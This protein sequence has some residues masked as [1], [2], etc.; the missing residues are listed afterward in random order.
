MTDDTRRPD[1]DDPDDDDDVHVLEEP[2]GTSYDD[3]LRELE[4]RGG[5]AESEGE[6]GVQ[7]I[8][9]APKPPLEVDQLAAER[10]ELHDRWLRTRADFDNYRKRAERDKRDS[11]DQA[12]IATVRTFLPVVDNLDRALDSARQHDAAGALLEGIEM[13]RFQLD[14]I[15]LSLG[16]ESVDPLGE[17]FDPE[18][19]EAIAREARDDVAPHQIVDVIQKGYKLRGRLVR[20]AMV[21]VAVGA[22]RDSDESK[23]QP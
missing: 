17:S 11:Y 7:P 21:R 2:E 6:S 13:I 5:E 9:E 19:H 20:P 14:E 23:D 8:D 10:A 3:I 1:G 18:L 4:D 12:V 16:V 15:L 22:D